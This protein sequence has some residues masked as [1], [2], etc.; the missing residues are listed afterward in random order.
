MSAEGEPSGSQPCGHADKKMWPL[1][2]QT[3]ESLKELIVA[4]PDFPLP[5][6]LFRDIMPI[7]Q[8][9]HASAS[10]IDLMVS[11]CESHYPAVECVVGLEARG[12]LFGPQMAINL[13]TAFVP[14]R[15]QGKL[16]GKC[17]SVDSTKEYGKDILEIQ[18]GAIKPGQKVVIVD[19]LLATGGTMKATVE[20]V[21]K[22][23]ADIVGCLCLIELAD[24][25]GVDKVDAPFHAF[26]SY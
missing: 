2:E 7:F 6:I 16:P 21:R 3:V 25:K 23:G 14:V 17:V 9:P 10:C 8:N 20:L 12:F 18:E 5:G 22:F 24:L 13:D 19:D 11:Y 26:I 15:K 4:V 1:P